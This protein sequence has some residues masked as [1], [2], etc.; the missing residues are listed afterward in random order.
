MTRLPKNQIKF[1]VGL[2]LNDSRELEKAILSIFY[3]IERKFKIKKTDDKIL[4][5][6][7]GFQKVF[8]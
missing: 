5:Y 8:F 7:L 1:I 4:L 3:G 2:K 6:M